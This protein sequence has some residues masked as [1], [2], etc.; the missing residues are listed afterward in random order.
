[1]FSRL[2]HPKAAI[3]MIKKILDWP[4]RFDTLSGHGT[5]LGVQPED[6]L[7][8]FFQSTQGVPV[9][10]EADIDRIDHYNGDS[11]TY[12]MGAT[13]HYWHNRRN[14]HLEIVNIDIERYEPGTQL[15]LCECTDMLFRKVDW[16]LELITDN[17]IE[18][19]DP[20]W[21]QLIQGS[22]TPATKPREDTFGAAYPDISLPPQYGIDIKSVV[23]RSTFQYKLV[24]SGCIVEISIYRTWEGRDTRGEPTVETSVSMFHESWKW[25]LDATNEKRDWD[26]YLTPLF[27][28]GTNDK[29]GIEAF[30]SEVGE[31]QSDLSDACR[32]YFDEL[33]PVSTNT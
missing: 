23:L 9:R 20:S 11:F 26:A 32:K 8:I 6:C 14:T 21:T 4:E 5:L 24:E 3:L 15:A 28:N 16:A 22:V 31:I 27:S 10:I 12:Q 1:M 7:C 33:E 19:P 29:N 2:P 18:Q 17:K 25:H 13:R 30:F